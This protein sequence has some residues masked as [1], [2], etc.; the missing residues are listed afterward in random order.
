MTKL[1]DTQQLI[2]HMQKALSD[3]TITLEEPESHPRQTEAMKVVE[4]GF[5]ALEA[6]ILPPSMLA[7][8]LA[9]LYQIPFAMSTL[10]DLGIPEILT[11][12]GGRGSTSDQIEERCGLPA[13][14]V[15]R[16]LRL[17]AGRGVFKEVRPDTW[18]HSSVSS[19]LDSGL[20]YEEV[21]KDPVGR[22]AK[23]AAL[24]ALINH[25]VEVGGAASNGMMGAFREEKW[26]QSFENDETL[27]NYAYKTRKSVC[28]SLILL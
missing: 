2:A 24:P 28:P 14:K 3:L 19:A 6:A 7:F 23:G 12:A 27:F 16:L 4:A 21:A 1:A 13:V 10:M 22:Y 17:L 18:A 8:R 5:G 26:K 20:T 9:F 25:C 15:S 11:E